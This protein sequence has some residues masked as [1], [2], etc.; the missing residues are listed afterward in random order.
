MQ[1]QEKINQL[2]IEQQK[3]WE[4]LKTAVEQL[5]RVQ[6]KEFTWGNELKVDVQF[7]PARITSASAKCRAIFLP[8]PP[9]SIN[10]TRSC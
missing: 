7:N 3:D 2:F 1:L 9:S 8:S 5:K 6:V 4:Q 10:A